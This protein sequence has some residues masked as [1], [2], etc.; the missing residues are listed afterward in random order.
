MNKL[1]EVGLLIGSWL[2]IF[3]IYFA[4]IFS[5][6]IMDLFQTKEGSAKK[7]LKEIK[8][9]LEKDKNRFNRQNY[10][11][12]FAD[13]FARMY[14]YGA[15]L[16][17]GLNKMTSEYDRE[18]RSRFKKEK[19][20]QRAIYSITIGMLEDVHKTDI[21]RIR[22]LINEYKKDIN[23]P[24]TP[25]ITKKQLEE[26]LA[27]LEKVLDQYLNHKDE[28]QKRVNNLINDEL[29]KLEDEDDKNSDKENKDDEKKDK[30]NTKEEK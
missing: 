16:A 4:M 26:D 2:L 28:F 1:G 8:E 15:Y 20:R 9:K 30:D 24:S 18:L 19:A 12:A 10:S 22:N 27:E 11:E 25:S 14:G 3:L 17:K 23:D 29:K 6:P 21:H 13:N 7:K 5:G